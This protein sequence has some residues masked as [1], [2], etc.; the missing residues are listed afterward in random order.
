MSPSTKVNLM[1]CQICGKKSGYYPICKEHYEMSRSGEVDKCDECGK[2]HLTS[3][4]CS[5]CESTSSEQ[6]SSESMTN[7]DPETPEA[8]RRWMD[9]NRPH[10]IPAFRHIFLE[11]VDLAD[12][13]RR[14]VSRADQSI[15]IINPYVSSGHVSNELMK[16]SKKG[17][18]VEVVTRTPDKQNYRDF[19]KKLNSAGIEPQYNETIH[20]KVI[21][22]DDSVVVV[23][24]MNMYAYSSGGG[25]WEAG[26]VSW[27][28]ETIES[29]RHCHERGF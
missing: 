29:I 10:I 13:S 9:E 21:L 22:V 17:V 18:S 1:P 24:S 19:H 12:F 5:T 16:A 4:G 8:V 20:A 7:W 2:W 6:T 28:P 27:D 3:T 14:L 25:V 26:I 23:S 15:L 11:G